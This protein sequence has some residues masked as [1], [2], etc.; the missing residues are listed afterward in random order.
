MTARNEEKVQKMNGNVRKNYRLRIRITDVMNTNKEI[1]R[2]ILPVDELNMTNVWAKI[3][4]KNVLGNKRT[5]GRTL[6]LTSWKL[7]GNKASIDPHEE[8]HKQLD[9]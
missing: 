8:P 7:P 3:V 1:V 9:E 4:P 2:Q 5:T 6:A